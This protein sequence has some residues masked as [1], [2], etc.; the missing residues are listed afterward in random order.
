M[1]H[2]DPSDFPELRKVLTG[3]L[4]EDFLQDHATAAAALKTFASDASERERERF[5]DEARRF[6][7]ATASLDFV[8]VRALLSRLGARWIPPT[9]EALAAALDA[10]APP[11]PG[12]PR[13]SKR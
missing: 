3:Y 5:Q 2:V 1:T 13:S 12:A 8:V 9:R 11:G 4:H 7:D 10:A 6:L